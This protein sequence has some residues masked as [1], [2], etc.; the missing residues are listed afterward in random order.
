MASTAEP[1]YLTSGDKSHLNRLSQ[2]DSRS[3]SLAPL[4][5]K[6]RECVIELNTLT[7]RPVP[8]KVSDLFYIYL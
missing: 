4:S 7:Q 8:E 2:W 5:D 3:T 1:T 6:Q